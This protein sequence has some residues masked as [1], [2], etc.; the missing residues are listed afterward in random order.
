M[1]VR[2]FINQSE[3]PLRVNFF[4]EFHIA[5][6]HFL[7][8]PRPSNSKNDQNEEKHIKCEKLEGA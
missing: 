2:L 3:G 5:D 8:L 4:S 7:S 1:D 6:F